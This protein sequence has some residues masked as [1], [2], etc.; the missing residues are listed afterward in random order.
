MNQI[1]HIKKEFDVQEVVFVGDRG[2]KIRYNLGTMNEADKEGVHYI[3]GLTHAEIRDL[4]K[5][6]VLQLNLFSKDIAE[7]EHEGR[8]IYT[9]SKSSTSGKRTELFKTIRA[10]VDDEIS[11]VK[12]AWE[13]VVKNIE[14]A[15]KLKMG[16]KI[17]I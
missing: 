1:N 6:D 5:K 11:D 7:V 9:F 17:K 15:E 2:M 13:N 4:L 16:I 8:K 12:A 14:N 10:L 3:T